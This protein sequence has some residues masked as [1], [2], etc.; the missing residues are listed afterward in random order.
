MQTFKKLGL[1]MMCLALVSPAFCQTRNANPQAVGLDVLI[2]D[3]IAFDTQ[4]DNNANWEAYADAMGDGSLI[5]VANTTAGSSGDLATERPAVGVVNPDLSYNEYAGAYDDAGNPWMENLD[6]ERS[7]GNPPVI[8]GDRRPGNRGYIVGNE[9]TPMD[10]GEFSSDN[11]WA[12]YLSHG[13]C[14]QAFDLSGGD[15]A[16]LFTLRDPAYQ[17]VDTTVGKGRVGGVMWLDNG[18]ILTETEDRDTFEYTAQSKSPI[19]TII[20]SQTGAWVK[21]P[22]IARDD[23]PNTDGWGGLTAFAGG[24][25]HRTNGTVTIEFFDNAGNQT[26]QWEQIPNDDDLNIPLTD[27]TDYTTSISTTGRGDGNHISSALSGTNIYYAGCGLNWIDF[28][29]NAPFVTKIDAITGTSVAEAMCHERVE[30]EG[31]ENYA[32]GHRA[33][34]FVAENEAVIVAWSDSANGGGGD[35]QIMCRVFDADLN[36]VTET[37]LAFQASNLEA[38][39]DIEFKHAQCAISDVGILVTCRAQAGF[40]P[41]NQHA[42]TVFENPLAEQPVEEWELY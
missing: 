16:P 19:L 4:S 24:F 34:C 2:E 32:A 7:D 9:C 21:S 28:S 25:A 18:N 40:G 33:S 11:R 13:F 12:G 3:T 15:P 41:I 29:S 26:A 10:F 27:F 30:V 31:Y 36:P 20:D 1:V 23:D 8:A 38:G 17:Y 6:N 14:V 39:S 22:F 5:F 35:G 37:F 42:F